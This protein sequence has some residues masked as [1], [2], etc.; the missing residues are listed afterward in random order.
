MGSFSG[1]YFGE[2][3]SGKISGISR[4][5][6]NYF[7]GIFTDKQRCI[8]L[9]AWK[10]MHDA[11]SRYRGATNSIFKT[12]SLAHT[13]RFLLLAE[14]LACLILRIVVSDKSLWYVLPAH[15]K[16]SSITTKIFVFSDKSRAVCA[17]LYESS[18]VWSRLFPWLWQCR[19]LFI[20][21]SRTSN[22]I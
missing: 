14:F 3:I 18:V 8:F 1:I 11:F 10:W 6:V 12:L 13:A 2:N 15:S 17:R 4:E 20:R 7:W 9:K 5:L 21:N 22:K 16:F 19:R